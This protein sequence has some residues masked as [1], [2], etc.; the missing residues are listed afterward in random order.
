VFY[1][2]SETFDAWHPVAD[3]FSSVSG[4]YGYGYAAEIAA[5]LFAPYAATGSEV[6]A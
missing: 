4:V 3:D 1:V 5:E 2:G 6:S